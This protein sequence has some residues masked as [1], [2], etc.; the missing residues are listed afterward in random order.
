[1]DAGASLRSPQFSTIDNYS[2]IVDAL[3][4]TDDL[5]FSIRRR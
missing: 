3:V 5:V 4:N 1:V 2:S